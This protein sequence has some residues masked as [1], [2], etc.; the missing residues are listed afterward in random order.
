MLID[1]LPF[2]RVAYLAIDPGLTTG[3]AAFD[4]S[5]ELIGMGQV[6]GIDQ[7]DDKLGNFSRLLAII[8]EDFLHNPNVPQGGSRGPAQQVIALVRRY[9]RYA[10]VKLVMQA[11]RILKVGYAWACI[12]QLPKSR[13]AE[14]HQFDAVAHGV[15]YLQRNG[16][17]R[18]SLDDPAM[19]NGEQ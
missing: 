1:D 5:G 17:R 3:W 10:K 11:S 15:Y 8:C 9:S 2:H 7:F 6:H 16:I 13:H 18:S 4:I 19:G 14:S 12:K